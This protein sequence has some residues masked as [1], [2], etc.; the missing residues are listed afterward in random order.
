MSSSKRLETDRLI[1]RVPE[2][3]DFDAFADMWADESVNKHIS[4][5]TWPRDASWGKFKSNVGQWALM[6]YGQWSLISKADGHYVGQVGFFD[7]DRG[8]GA[9][10]D[11]CREAG[12]VL[13]P[14]QDGQGYATEAMLTAHAWIDQQRFGG[15]TVCMMDANYL[16]S[17]RVA[18]KCGYT[19]LRRTSDDFGDVVLL[20]RLAG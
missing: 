5:K 4:G 10:F 2:M 9:D 20:E 11:T 13:A 6:G 15:R 8:M 1:L 14:D 18:D 16:A 3:A 12:W 7:A 17:R 19:E